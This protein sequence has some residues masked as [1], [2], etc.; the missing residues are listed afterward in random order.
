MRPCLKIKSKERVKEYSSHLEWF[1][2]VQ[3][4]L[5]STSKNV[6][7][8]VHLEQGW[9]RGKEIKIKL[10]VSLFDAKEKSALLKA[11]FLARKSHFRIQMQLINVI[12]PNNCGLTLASA[13]HHPTGVLSLSMLPVAS[14]CTA[15]ETGIL[16]PQLGDL[17][18]LGLSRTVLL[19]SMRASKRQKT[20]CL[21]IRKDWKFFLFF[22][23]LIINIRAYVR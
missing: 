1:P 13:G 4:T 16:P 7:M 17:Q 23:F 15:A 19:F 2:H 8:S 18:F 20:S 9:G 11:Y 12:P 14:P 5:V 10:L 21:W 3:E 22:N 6:Y